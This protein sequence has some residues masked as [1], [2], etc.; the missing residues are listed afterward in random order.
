MKVT[1]AVMLKVTV[2]GNAGRVCVDCSLTG[3][4]LANAL[5][6]KRCVS[7]N[8]RRK[9]LRSC[10]LPLSPCGG[11][12]DQ[13]DFCTFIRHTAFHTPHFKHNIQHLPVV[14]VH[15]AITEGF[16]SLSLDSTW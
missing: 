7:S 8:E 12:Y 13:E 15:T 2:T 16:P 3:R 9:D 11:E 4:R 6:V 1:F 10:C 5:D 14:M